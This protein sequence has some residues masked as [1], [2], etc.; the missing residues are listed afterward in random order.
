MMIT[1][2]ASFPPREC[3][4]ATF[5][6]DLSQSVARIPGQETFQVAAITEEEGHHHYPPNVRYL[7]D[8]GDPESY[9][10]AALAINKTN[11]D[12]VSVQHEF[13][14]YGVWDGTLVADHA[15][16]MLES[17][18]KP[19]VTTL[20][21]VLP[22]PDENIKRSIRQIVELSDA[23]TVMVRMA[24]LLLIEDYGV[25]EEKIFTIPHGV[26][27]V[28]HRVHPDKIKPEYRLEGQVV[29]S[30]FGLINEGK[31]ID[32]VIEALPSIV[33]HTPNVIYLIIGET[34]PEVRK[35]YG[36]AYRNRLMQRAKDLGVS[37]HV[38]FVNRFLPQGELVNYLLATDIYITP[39]NSRHQITS[40]TLA[41][42]LGC[43]KAIVST[44]YLYAQEALAEGRGILAEF[45]SP[46]SIANCVNQILLTPGLK[47]HMEREAYRYGRK[48]AWSNVGQQYLDLF[49]QVLANAKTTSPLRS[50]HLSAPEQTIS[51]D[52][53]PDVN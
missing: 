38:R 12:I 32:L 34:H 9:V 49:S 4:I 50:V 22:Y 15:P 1:Y 31:G 3:G 23:V 18:R 37:S 24:G 40:G 17:L 51:V 44:P 46:E 43:G 7:I 29:L 11:D 20:H 35:R 25:P 6:R 21:T 8:Q 10:A 28:K 45:R 2:V 39:Y 47:E 53:P 41:Y 16:A 26:P 36:E 30:T 48:M 42:A 52:S 19:K 33:E 14:L 5:T 13:G 27:Q